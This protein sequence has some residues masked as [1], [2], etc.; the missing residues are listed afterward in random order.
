MEVQL[1]AVGF[2]YP[3]SYMRQAVG[4]SLHEGHSAMMKRI[5]FGII[6][7]YLLVAI[8]TTLAEASGFGRQCAC[9]QDCWCKKP[10]LRLFRWVTPKR[11][12]RLLN[13]ADKQLL[14]EAKG[15]N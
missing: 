10:G 1:D 4:R 15:S 6:G 9:E 8:V 14:A 2:A 3:V 7:L 5:L 12:H 13:P 11:K